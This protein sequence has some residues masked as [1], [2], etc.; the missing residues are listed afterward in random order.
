MARSQRDSEITSADLDIAWQVVLA[1]T[2][3]E[4]RAWGSV[5]GSPNCVVEGIQELDL[6]G[7]LCLGDREVLI[8]E[9]PTV[10]RLAPESGKARGK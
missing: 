9:I 3:P 10:Q 6:N 1:V 5:F 7:N 2:L 8:I 4:V